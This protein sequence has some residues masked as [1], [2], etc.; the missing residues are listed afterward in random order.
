LNVHLKVRSAVLG[1]KGKVG[2]LAHDIYDGVKPEEIR[3]ALVLGTCWLQ[4]EEGMQQAFR[5]HHF[6]PNWQVFHRTV[7]AGNMLG[8]NSDDASKAISTHSA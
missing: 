3:H 7:P 5:A 4:Q 8:N 1:H 2:V 6:Q